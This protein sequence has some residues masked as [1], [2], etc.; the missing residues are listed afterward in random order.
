MIMW[1]AFESK[2]ATIQEA[3]YAFTSMAMEPA[4]KNFWKSKLVMLRRTSIQLAE[5]ILV[6]Q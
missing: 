5:E 3:L 4:H 6:L 1:A 2:R